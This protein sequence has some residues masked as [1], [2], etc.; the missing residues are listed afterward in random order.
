M[1]HKTAKARFAPRIHFFPAK[2]KKKS[3]TEEKFSQKLKPT[4]DGHKT[5]HREARLR[6]QADEADQHEEEQQDPADGRHCQGIRQSERRKQNNTKFVEKQHH[7]RP[8]EHQGPHQ[9]GGAVSL[10]QQDQ[11]ASARDWQSYTAAD[12][13]AQ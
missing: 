6:L 5:S 7:R 2:E 3:L 9:L 10:R 4:S 12:A 13:R 11:H 8:V 1:N